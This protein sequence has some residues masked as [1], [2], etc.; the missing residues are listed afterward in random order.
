MMEESDKKYPV[1]EQG[2]QLSGR[3]RPGLHK[4]LGLNSN[5]TKKIRRKKE[6]RVGGREKRKVGRKK[7]RQT[8]IKKEHL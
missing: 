6:R 4:V 8:D 5:A 7:D 1:T 3:D 2:I